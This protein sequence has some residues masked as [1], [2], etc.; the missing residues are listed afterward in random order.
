M[1]LRI[2]HMRGCNPSHGLPLTYHAQAHQESAHAAPP[3]ASTVRVNNATTS[4][5]Y[6]FLEVS[7]VLCTRQ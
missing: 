2:F 1:R 7:A 5:F 4:T 3:S 6:F